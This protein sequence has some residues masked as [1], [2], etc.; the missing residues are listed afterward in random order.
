MKKLEQLIEDIKAGKEPEVSQE[1]WDLANKVCK[2][3]PGD[4]LKE[5]AYTLAEDIVEAEEE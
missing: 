1:M 2:E 5:W 3:I 4:S